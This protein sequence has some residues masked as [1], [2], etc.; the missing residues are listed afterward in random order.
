MEGKTVL[1]TGASAGIG[2]ALAAEFAAHGHD[3]ILVARSVD[4]LRELAFELSGRHGVRA[5]HIP[6]NLSKRRSA[7]ALAVAVRQRD[8]QVDILVNNAGV[9]EAGAFRHADADDLHRMVQLNVATLTQL[10]H[11]FLG[12]MVARGYGRILNVASVAG[13]QPVPGLAA[14]AATKAYVLSLSE[15]LNE[16]LRGSGVSVTTLCPGVTDTDM[17]QQVRQLNPELPQ[18]PPLLLSSVRS[19]AR[20]GYRA[21]MRGEVI[22]VPGLANRIGTFWSQVQPRWVVRTLGGLVGRQLLKDR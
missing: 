14:Y 9:L 16:E 15:A 4:K 13:F 20:E 22:R 5:V 21:C 2:R 3:L 11:V 18:I 7:G 10:T 8:L 1:I 19:V 17:A 12:P 6:M